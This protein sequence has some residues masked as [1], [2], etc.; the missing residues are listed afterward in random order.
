MS[1]AWKV[2]DAGGSAEDVHGRAA[3]TLAFAFLQCLEQRMLQA[4]DIIASVIEDA[5]GTIRDERSAAGTWCLSP[6]PIVPHAA[7]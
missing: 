7:C 1:P 6:G 4:L 5:G 3:S 2:L